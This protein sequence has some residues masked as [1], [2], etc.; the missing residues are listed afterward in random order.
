MPVQDS[1]EDVGS[2]LV[3]GKRGMKRA[4]LEVI[5]SRAVATAQDVLR[6]IKC[7]LLAATTDYEVVQHLLC[8]PAVPCCSCLVMAMELFSKSICL[9]LCAHACCDRRW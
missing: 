8:S 9:T 5:A 6:F 7:T 3:E 1:L 4:L 2:C